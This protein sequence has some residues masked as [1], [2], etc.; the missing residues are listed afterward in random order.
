MDLKNRNMTLY[1]YVRKNKKYLLKN[2]FYYDEEKL[3]EKMKDVTFLHFKQYN[4]RIY[5]TCL[6]NKDFNRIINYYKNLDYNKYFYLDINLEEIKN[7]C[8]LY[9]TIKDFRKNYNL[10]YK[11]LSK[12]N[13]LDEFFKHTNTLKMR[14]NLFYK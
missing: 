6:R 8:I 4:K 1:K 10:I 7:I 5:N 3:L 9:N 13:L 14:N 2:M 12:N 11:Y